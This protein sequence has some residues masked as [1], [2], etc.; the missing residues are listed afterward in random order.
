MCWCTPR[1]LCR[2]RWRSPGLSWWSFTQASTALDTD[3]TA[4]LVDVQPDGYARNLQ[5]GIIRARYRD[6]RSSPSLIVANQVYKYSIDLCAT[7]YLFKAGHRVRLEISS[8]NF[9]RFDRNL[10]TGARPGEGSVGEPAKQ[11]L[12]HSAAYPSHILLPVI[13]R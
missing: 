2:R 9:P 12:C 3:F 4:K 8:S 6:S 5:D 11:T 13:P 7:S 10:N 1:S